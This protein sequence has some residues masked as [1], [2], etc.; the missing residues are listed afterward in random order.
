MEAYTE[1]MREVIC[2]NCRLDQGSGDC[3]RPDDQVCPL[4]TYYPLVVEI[5][6]GELAAG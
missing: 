5:I 3:G 4:D 1:R 2:S 6:E